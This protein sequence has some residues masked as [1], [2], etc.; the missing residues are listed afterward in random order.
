MK[1]EIFVK[2]FN[3]SFLD[4]QYET[5]RVL[6]LAVNPKLQIAIVEYNSHFSGCIGCI[7]DYLYGEVNQCNGLWSKVIID[8]KEV[9]IKR[10]RFKSFILKMRK[11]LRNTYGDLYAPFKPPIS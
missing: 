2:N 6:Q 9:H 8:G 10:A 3:N 11:Y 7:L 1:I 4:P 5:R